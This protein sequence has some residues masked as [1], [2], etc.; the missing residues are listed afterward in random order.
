MRIL[1]VA[2]EFSGDNAINAIPEMRAISAKHT[3]YSL[4]GKDVTVRE[5]FEVADRWKFNI[6]HYAS[7][8]SE[9]GIEMSDGEILDPA[10]CALVARTAKASVV[11]FGGCDSG[12]LA[13][14]VINFGVDYAVYAN[15]DLTTNEFWKFTLAFYN[16]FPNGHADNVLGSYLAASNK[17]GT[18]GWTM[19]PEIAVEAIRIYSLQK[20]VQAI[21]S[22]KSWQ[23]IA[24]L[25]LGTISI[26]MS[27]VA[28]VR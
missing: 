19:N 18:I 5:L 27:L 17:D 4:V 28:I 11:V 13:S 26:I 6:I 23:I 3:V 10:D 15:R 24:L 14:Y 21:K 9:R 2:P 20:Q 25:L 22:I 1:F 7:H 12:V 16:A 8:M